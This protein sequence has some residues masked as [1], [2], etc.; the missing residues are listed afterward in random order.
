[1]TKKGLG[2]TQKRRAKTF[3]L[4]GKVFNYIE[5]TNKEQATSGVKIDWSMVVDNTI[6]QWIETFGGG[7]KP[8]DLKDNEVQESEILERNEDEQ[9]WCTDFN[10]QSAGFELTEGTNPIDIG[11]KT[12]F[13][14]KCSVCGIEK[15][16]SKVLADKMLREMNPNL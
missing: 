8:E 15:M 6:V 11:G 3:T 10:C 5:R 13:K 4:S 9:W 14:A 12:Y 2:T 1:M 16:V 7:F